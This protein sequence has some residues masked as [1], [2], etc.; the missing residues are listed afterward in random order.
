MEDKPMIP[1]WFLHRWFYHLS[2]LTHSWHWVAVCHEQHK[3]AWGLWPSLGNSYGTWISRYLIAAVAAPETPA[4][5]PTP[6]VRPTTDN[7]MNTPDSALATKGAY[8]SLWWC[9]EP[10]Y[11]CYCNRAA[12][13]TPIR[14]PI[15]EREKRERDCV[16]MCVCLCVCM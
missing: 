1:E 3:M 5:S 2:W 11:L 12:I 10:F 9:W 4:I 15:E 14:L 13:N 8:H 16:C 7:A 6:S